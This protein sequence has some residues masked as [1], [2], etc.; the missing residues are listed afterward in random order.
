MIIKNNNHD[1]HNKVYKYDKYKYN[2][3]KVKFSQFTF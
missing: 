2:I 3:Y 1:H